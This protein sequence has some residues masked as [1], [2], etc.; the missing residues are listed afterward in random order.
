MTTRWQHGFNSWQHLS[1][2]H[3]HMGASTWQPHCHLHEDETCSIL[4]SYKAQLTFQPASWT[5]ASSL[6]WLQILKHG[7]SP[8][9][10]Y[11]CIIT[12]RCSWYSCNAH[13]LSKASSYDL[14]ARPSPKP[15]LYSQDA[16][17]WYQPLAWQIRCIVRVSRR[18]TCSQDRV[19]A[20][21]K[22]RPSHLYHECAWQERTKSE[23]A[24]WTAWEMLRA[25][26]VLDFCKI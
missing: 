18:G 2:I 16:T 6:P 11:H 1:I 23:N 12:R 8:N 7:L 20:L 15:G 21:S 13:F 19:E 3:H 25:N 17:S 24:E 5:K 14:A 4:S 22:R 9:K 10:P 26:C